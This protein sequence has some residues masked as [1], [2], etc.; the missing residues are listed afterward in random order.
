MVVYVGIDEPR[1]SSYYGGQVAAPVFRKIAEPALRYLK[2]PVQ[3][4]L[5]R[6]VIADDAFPAPLE[7]PQ[8][9]VEEEGKMWRLPSFAGKT[10][11]EVLLAFG[12]APVQ[13]R[14]EG[15]GV[16]R[17]QEPPAGTLVPKHAVCR[18][19]FESLF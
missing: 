7:E 10:M 17:T 4:S 16:A 14:F 11:R 12:D 9:A 15:S 18:V 1:T 13:L 2:V 5:P 8:I 19:K 3:T 6:M